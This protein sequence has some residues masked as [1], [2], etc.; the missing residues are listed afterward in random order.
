MFWAGGPDPHK[1]GV[2]QVPRI[3]GPGILAVSLKSPG[4]TEYAGSQMPS[5]LHRYQDCGELHFLTFSCYRRLP[6]LGTGEARELLESALERVRRKYRCAVLGYV[7]MPEHVHLLV[8]EPTSSSLDRV[9]KS[10][11]LSVALRRPERPFWQA[12]YYDFNVWT[13]RKRVE[14]LRYIHRNPVARGLVEKPEDWAWSSFRHY[15]AGVK[16]MVEIESFWTGWRRENGR[17]HSQVP[18]SEGPGAPPPQIGGQID[19]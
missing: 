18:K 3:W 9:I 14:K 4:S 19:S 16:G 6:Y 17:L 8:N 2:P 13:E 7:V 11:K 5:G 12:R 10:I 15:A 1:T